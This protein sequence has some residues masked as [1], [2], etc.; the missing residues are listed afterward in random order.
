MLDQE[1]KTAT[2]PASRGKTETGAYVF[3]LLLTVVAVGIAVVL[4]ERVSSVLIP[5]LQAVFVALVASKPVAFLERHR[6]PRVLS[7]LVVVLCIVSLVAAVA[8]LVGAGLI[9]VAQGLLAYEAR[10]QELKARFAELFL[11][12]GIELPPQILG[13]VLDRQSIMGL[14]A[15]VAGS[16]GGSIVRTFFVVLIATY[17]LLDAPNIRRRLQKLA[18]GGVDPDV[19]IKR[20]TTM[21]Y[22]YLLIRT[23]ASIGTGAMAGGLI[24][25]IGVPHAL[26]WAL[27]ALILNYIPQVGS[28]IAAIIPAILALITL[29]TL[30]AVLTLGAF[31]LAN[32]I[33]G[34]VV[35]PR[36]L[37]LRFGLP[38]VLILFSLV[39]W[40]WI[41]DATGV[42]LAV[43]LTMSVI[44]FLDRYSSTRRIA[45]LLV[46]EEGL[47]RARTE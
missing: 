28:V 37:G 3:R 41:F 8:T 14:I 47:P 45:Y 44:F 40:G 13:G 9:D 22:R 26:L 21:I 31:L 24:A 12:V 36:L 10:F 29:G 32:L 35:E 15:V 42:F 27:V 19:T 16:L 38:V 39:F 18:H 5:F 7:A 34:N 6:V 23:V 43:P 25:L 17:A 4:M 46:G 2:P 1:S 20:F 30:K 33:F 11:R